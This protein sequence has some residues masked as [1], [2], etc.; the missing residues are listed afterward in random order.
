MKYCPICRITYT[1]EDLLFCL[2]DGTRLHDYSVETSAMPTQTFD[3]TETVIRQNRP[4]SDWGRSQVTLAAT[5]P[6]P[7]LEQSDSLFAT[8]LAALLI[9]VLF[10]VI[11]GIWT[12]LKDDNNAG[13]KTTSGNYSGNRFDATPP[14]TTPTNTPVKKNGV[15]TEKDKTDFGSFG[16]DRQFIGC[17]RDKQPF[18]LDGY[19]KAGDNNTPEICIALC[20]AGGFKYAGV[21]DGKS[22]LCGN[23]Y[24]KYGTADNCNIKCTGDSGQNCGGYNA[25]SIYT[26][27]I[28]KACD[29]FLSSVIYDKWEQLGGKNGRLGCPTMNETET[30]SSLKGTTGRMTRFSKGDGGFIVRHE[31]GKF[32]GTAFAVSGCMFKL[33]ADLGGTKSWLGFPIQ[34]EFSNFA[35][36]RQDFENGYILWDSKTYNCQAYKN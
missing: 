7:P 32:D 6:S 24:G 5:P 8:L 31:S 33:Y 1:D 21:Q 19:L 20:H 9:V 18:D 23:S 30:E 16:K 27:E 3:E 28:L 15:V 11:A 17:F 34:D 12:F 4:P 13:G 26:T 10:G 2:E 29:Y 14:I 36:A 22:C 25:N 35:G